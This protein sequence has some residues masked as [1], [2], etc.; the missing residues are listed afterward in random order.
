[1]LA[2]VVSVCLFPVGEH[3]AADAATV[4]SAHRHNG[5]SLTSQAVLLARHGADCF[6]HFF[7]LS[8]LEYA[9]TC[10]FALMSS[11]SCRFLAQSSPCL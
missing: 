2:P 5:L 9:K 8:D 6:N 3:L 1:M 10:F 11:L 7:V 4:D